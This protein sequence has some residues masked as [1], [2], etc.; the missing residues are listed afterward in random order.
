MHEQQSFLQRP[1]SVDGNDGVTA[2]IE[3]LERAVMQL[4]NRVEAGS[5]LPEK[6]EQPE[7]TEDSN[8]IL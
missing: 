6:I 7:L 8:D 5:V 3:L 2:Q 4:L 1:V